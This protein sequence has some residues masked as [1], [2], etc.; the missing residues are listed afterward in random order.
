MA[1]G[2][3]QATPPMGQQM[4]RSPM[5]PAGGQ[6]G[7]PAAP[8]GQTMPMTGQQMPGQVGQLGGLF[9]GVGGGMA[10]IPGQQMPM[11]QTQQFQNPMTSTGLASIAPQPSGLQHYGPQIRNS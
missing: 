5:A 10:G 2:A 8:G 7:K 6:A 11:Q 9:G 4:M 3:G 1:G